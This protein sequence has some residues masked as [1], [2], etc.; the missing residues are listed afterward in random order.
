MAG[1]ETERPQAGKE[2]DPA[3]GSSNGSP[4]EEEAQGSAVPSAAEPSQPEEPTSVPEDE[5]V[6]RPPEIPPPAPV[7]PVVPPLPPV[8][9]PTVPG[10]RPA[11]PS[12]LPRLL[13]YLVIFAL[14]ALVSIGAAFILSF[15]AGPPSQVGSDLEPRLS[16][17][18]TRVAALEHKQGATATSLN[19]IEA[20]LRAVEAT[21]AQAAGAAREA[22]KAL[23]ARSS[24]EAGAEA[25]SNPAPDLGPLV[26][27]LD[28]LERRLE[29]QRVSLVGQH[30]AEARDGSGDA[31]K[32]HA[33]AIV[34]GR[35]IQEIDRGEAFTHEVGT[36][37]A[38]GVDDAKLAPLRVFAG[39]G[40]ASA[41]RLGETFARLT[42]AILSTERGGSEETSLVERLKGYASNLVH[43]ERTEDLESNELRGLV[44]RIKLALA[45]GHADDA[46]RLWTELPD[47][48]RAVSEG[49]GTAAK[50]RL[51]TLNTARSI[52]ADA[53]AALGKPKS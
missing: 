11:R 52:E 42:P 40:V 53:V 19:A 22:E 29:E 26:A 38:L 33:V 48:A 50:N 30:G 27:R 1:D 49:F 24:A 28:A 45:H 3:T 14:G 17:S 36:L 13:L 43:V 32:A 10:P 41:H 21:A 16:A 5:V 31:A 12:I 37:A 44:A 9:E 23:A 15:L 8:T 25:G 35:L 2:P 6:A 51:D 47:P 34:A 18:D 4:P 39:A 20:R 7:E 46:Y